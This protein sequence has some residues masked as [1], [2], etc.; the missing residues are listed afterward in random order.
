MIL[1][2]SAAHYCMPV[3][4]ESHARTHLRYRPIIFTHLP[5][6]NRICNREC[7]AAF[8]NNLLGLSSSPSKLLGLETLWHRRVK[9]NPAFLYTIHHDNVH[10]ATNATSDTFGPLRQLRSKYYSPV[11]L[12]NVRL[13]IYLIQT[14]FGL[15]GAIDLLHGSVSEFKFSYCYLTF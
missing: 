11:K 3:T 12:I 2:S 15:D 7:A 5:D 6:V 10:S 8:T 14:N 4:N 9:L 13:F 1:S